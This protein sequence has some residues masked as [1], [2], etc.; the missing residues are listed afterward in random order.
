MHLWCSEAKLHRQLCATT[1]SVVVECL[2]S[3]ISNPYHMLN[4]QGSYVFVIDNSANSFY[5]KSI[6]TGFVV[7]VLHSS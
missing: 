6:M 5:S 2:K 4:F 7:L 1:V 3:L